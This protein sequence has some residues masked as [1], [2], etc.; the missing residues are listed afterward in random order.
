[1]PRPMRSRLSMELSCRG[2]SLKVGPLLF[3]R[4]GRSKPRWSTACPIMPRHRRSGRYRRR[5]EAW[6][7]APAV[8]QC[9]AR[10]ACLRSGERPPAA[11]RIDRDI[12]AILEIQP[13]VCH[14]GTARTRGRRAPLPVGDAGPPPGRDNHN[15]GSRHE[16]AHGTRRGAAV[17]GVPVRL[18]AGGQDQV[19]VGEPRRQL[20]RRVRARVQEAR[21]GALRRADPGRRPPR[22]PARL[23][24]ATSTRYRAGSSTW[25]A[26]R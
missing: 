19:R 17:R 14:V 20:S 2:A 4:V 22:W 7:P 8:L 16:E 5:P 24:Q 18:R 21:G 6:G 1:M 26:R 12:G 13:R 23:E 10:S 3:R 9:V 11:N 15:L 25:R